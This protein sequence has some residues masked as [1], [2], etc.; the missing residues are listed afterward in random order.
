MANFASLPNVLASREHDTRGGGRLSG[1]W[2]CR[3]RRKHQRQW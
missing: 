2:R 3:Q 1:D